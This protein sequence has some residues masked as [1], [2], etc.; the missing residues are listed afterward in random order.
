M[1]TI[2]LLV[3]S[4]RRA[5]TTQ[6]YSGVIIIDGNRFR[7]ALDNWK[8]MIAIKH[9]RLKLKA[10]IASA[11]KQPGRYKDLGEEITYWFDIWKRIFV[12]VESKT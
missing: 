5:N 12:R 10:M 4:T 11:L 2:Y 7:F 1:A 8:T 6:M 3:T 9:L